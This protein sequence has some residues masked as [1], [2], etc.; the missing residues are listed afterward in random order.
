MLTEFAPSTFLRMRGLE[1]VASR[2]APN[3]DQFGL[4]NAQGNLLTSKF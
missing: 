3:S 1:A 4:L 2:A